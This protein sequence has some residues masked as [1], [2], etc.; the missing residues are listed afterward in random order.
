MLIAVKNSI[1][2]LEIF[3]NTRVEEVF[4]CCSVNNTTIIVRCV[5][6]PHC[7]MIEH[8]KNHCS[9]IQMLSKRFSDDQFIIVGDFNRPNVA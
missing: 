3:N 7:G 4:V 9:N 2:V 1:Q 5:Y 6:L 8:Y